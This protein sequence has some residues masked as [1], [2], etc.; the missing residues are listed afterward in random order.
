M[1]DFKDK[2]AV[3][4]GGATG[5]GFAM[6]KALGQEGAR[7]I[8]A[9]MRED[10]LQQSVQTLSDLGVDAKYTLC[11]VTS[12]EEVEALAD[13]A[14]DTNGSVDMVFNNAGIGNPQA[15]IS[16]MPMEEVRAVFDVNFF[17]VWHG[18][19]VFSKR[20]SEQGTPAGIYNTCSENGLFNAVPFHAAYVAS[21][22]AVLGLTDSLREQ[23]PDFIEV[24]CIC[25]GWV[26]SEMMSEEMGNM[27]MDTDRFAGLVL[28][29]IRAG[30][31][32]IISHSYNMVRIQ[33]R[34]DEISGAFNEYAPRYEG[35]EE[36]DI[37][38]LMANLSG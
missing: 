17:G 5:I 1:K 36:Y 19:R 11:D 25:P 10:R 29:Q 35:D 15:P 14:F 13:F 30:S 18:S 12:L 6:A 20:L 31:F 34:Y 9:E 2:T 38:T 8:I 16:E 33:D 37:R 7:I 21:K 4:T 22:H 27:A 28:D 24:G 26:K 23:V 3:I 32:F